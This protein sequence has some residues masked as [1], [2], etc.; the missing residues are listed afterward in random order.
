MTETQT[1]NLDMD[2]SVES[3]EESASPSADD[4]F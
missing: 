1:D 3:P 4:F 2:V